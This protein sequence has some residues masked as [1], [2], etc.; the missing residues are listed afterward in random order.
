M[1]ITHSAWVVLDE[2]SRANAECS[3]RVANLEHGAMNRTL[4]AVAIVVAV[5]AA[6]GALVIGAGLYNVAADEAHSPLVYRVLET[7][8]ERSI[9]VRA[10][11]I[12]VP[13]SRVR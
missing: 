4:L 6:L 13:G 11:G 8:R 3:P 2:H 10:R 7:A 1:T 5:L 12:G 9:G